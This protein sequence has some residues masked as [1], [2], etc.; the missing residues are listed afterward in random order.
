MSPRRKKLIGTLIIL[1]WIPVYVFVAMRIAFAVLP[2]GGLIAFVFYP[3][4][5]MLWIVPIGLMFPWM[6]REPTVRRPPR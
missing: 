5:G 1:V 4:A 6:N 2:T 3:L